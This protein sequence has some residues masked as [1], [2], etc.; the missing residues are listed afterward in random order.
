MPRF[1]TL[2][3]SMPHTPFCVFVGRS[4]RD[5]GLTL[6]AVYGLY[7]L[8]HGKGVLTVDGKYQISFAGSK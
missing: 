6:L 5:S 2:D 8:L 1:G 4:F 3:G 7:T